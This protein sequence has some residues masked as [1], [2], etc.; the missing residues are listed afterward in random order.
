MN[1]SRSS[2]SSHRPPYIIIAGHSGS[3]KTH[4]VTRMVRVLMNSGMSIGCV[5]HCPSGFQFDREGS[6]SDLYTRAGA[7]QIA[8]AGDDTL[9]FINRTRKPELER[10][11]TRFAG[12]DLVLVEGYSSARGTAVWVSR[13]GSIPREREDG[14]FR[15]LHYPVSDDEVASLCRAILAELP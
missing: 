1:R 10:V 8:I 6:D 12:V 4:L 11:L 7:A 15:H 3:G 13:D 5:K 2:L 9:V 14:Y